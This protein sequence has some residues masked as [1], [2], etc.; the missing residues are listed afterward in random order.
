M[1]LVDRKEFKLF[2]GTLTGFIVMAGALLVFS[3]SVTGDALEGP[4]YLY[5]QARYG[6]R[7]DAEKEQLLIDRIEAVP[8]VVKTE[9]TLESPLAG[10]R[11]RFLEVWVSPLDDKVERKIT[12]LCSKNGLWWSEY[13]MTCL[14]LNIESGRTSRLN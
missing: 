4:K 9:F 12:N 7:T 6:S 2:I 5:D 1:R 10:P 3:K 8:Q 14:V 11:D 13:S